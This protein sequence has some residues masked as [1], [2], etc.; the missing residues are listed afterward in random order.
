MVSL[1]ID[2]LNVSDGMD[3]HNTHFQFDELVKG[4][5]FLSDKMRTVK[6]EVERK[7]WLQLYYFTEK[8]FK[9]QPSI[10]RRLWSKCLS[11]IRPEGKPGS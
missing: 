3:T 11:S 2:T 10:H 8:K 4:R 9:H 6:K 7:I 1:L 5:E